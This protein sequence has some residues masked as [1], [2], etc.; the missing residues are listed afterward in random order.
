M[1][2]IIRAVI[3]ATFAGMALAGCGV[4]GPLEAPGGPAAAEQKAAAGA[5]KAHQ[6]FILDGLLR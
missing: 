5:P 3:V 4:N 6:P 1:A 2:N